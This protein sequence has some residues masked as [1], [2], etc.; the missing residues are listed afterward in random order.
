MA[1]AKNLENFY[2]DW[3]FVT[4]GKM[5]LYDA[6]VWCIKTIGVKAL[7]WDNK[8]NLYNVV[9]R[10]KNKDDALMFLLKFGG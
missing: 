7:K 5:H 9:Y 4:V 2:D 10:F 3:H 8:I 6:S 1:I